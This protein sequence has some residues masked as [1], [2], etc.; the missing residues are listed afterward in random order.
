MHHLNERESVYFSP[1]VFNSILNVF[2]DGLQFRH[3]T[4]RRISYRER[5]AY[6][7][8]SILM[9]T[10]VSLVIASTGDTVATQPVESMLLSTEASGNGGI[11]RES[12]R[13]TNDGGNRIG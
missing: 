7:G 5:S 3:H 1:I 10:L 11:R 12:S 8:S 6:L 13:E 2:C 9:S 4:D